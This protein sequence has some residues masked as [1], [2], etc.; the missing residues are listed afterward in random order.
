MKI[1]CLHGYG[2]NAAVLENQMQVFLSVADKEIEPMYLE[3]EID[4]PKAGSEHT[5]AIHSNAVRLYFPP[6]KRNPGLSA[7]TKGPFFCYYSAFD[8]LSIKKSHEMLAE[9][10][11]ED[12]PFDGIVGFSQGGSLAVSYLLQHEIDHPNEAM[13]FKFAVIFSSII[14]FTPDPSY[15]E[16]IIRNL[17]EPEFKALSKFPE[18]DFSILPSGAR[19]L[20]ECMAEALRAGQEG[21]FL[22]AHPD[23]DVFSRGETDMIPRV[24]HPELVTTRIRIPTVHVVGKEDHALMIRQ[25]KLMYGV[26]DPVV[27]KWLVHSGG[28]DV[29]RQVGDAKAVVK[30]MEWAVAESQ[31]QV[32][33]RL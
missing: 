32:W 11:E 1:L 22:Q 21:G 27:A 29:P 16:D 33:A 12:G 6:N 23:E 19:T 24:I 3:G 13:P 17:T 10:I 5:F 25:S 28:H 31:T 14:S 2:T 4:A 26:C 20:F 9:V 8:P 18:A 15:C 30:A 7:F